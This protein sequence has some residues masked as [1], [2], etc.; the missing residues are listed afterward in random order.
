MGM[1]TTTTPSPA[2]S[3]AH[4]KNPHKMLKRQDA[5]LSKGRR[6]MESLSKRGA[7]LG[8]VALAAALAVALGVWA[9]ARRDTHEA[10]AANAL[11][12]AQ[13]TL[14]AELKK[15]ASELVPLPKADPKKKE[16]SP[17]PGAEAIAFKRFN[18][19]AK[20]PEGLQALQNVAQTH[21]ST[22]AGFEASMKIGD[23]HFNHGD[24]TQALDWY[25]K[26]VDHARNS[27][28]KAFSWSAVGTVNENLG[29]SAE[30]MAAYE[31]AWASKEAS[32]DGEVALALARVQQTSGNSSAAKATYEKILKDLPNTEYAKTAESF[33][34][35]LK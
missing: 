2:H 10:T 4:T 7:L 30:A 33:K 20:L 1:A 19:E 31:K 9:L 14:D 22:R 32:L 34:A 26:G 13:K 27:L 23:L 6:L 12:S 24:A 17:P 5:F 15:V 8:G 35:R 18:V 28:Q 25:Q 11:Y 3:V 29:K 16:A 21:P